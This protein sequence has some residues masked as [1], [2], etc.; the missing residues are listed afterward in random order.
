MTL[1]EYILFWQETYAPAPSTPLDAPSPIGLR[2]R[3]LPGPFHV[4]SASQT[5]VL[6]T[7]E[8]L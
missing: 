3:Q 2:Q 6:C 5:E 7:T 1:R 8:Y 4:S